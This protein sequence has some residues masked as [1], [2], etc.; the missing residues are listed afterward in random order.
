MGKNLDFRVQT[1]GC[2]FLLP[3]KEQA[4]A[5]AAIHE[6]VSEDGVDDDL[7]EELRTWGWGTLTNNAGDIISLF[8]SMEYYEPDEA[9]SVLKAIAP[10]VK[11]NSFV[12]LAFDFNEG[13]SLN[14]FA[15]V[16]TERNG[17]PYVREEEA[18]VLPISQLP[19][20]KK[21]R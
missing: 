21:E 20:K 6:I 3:R 1:V 14:P 19:T 5:L 9:L 2:S 17:K 8:Y 7:R 12:A 11:K 15:F 10:F 18:K 4:A 16:F 13:E